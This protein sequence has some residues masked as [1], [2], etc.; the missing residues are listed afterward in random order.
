MD[1]RRGAKV[2][3][4]DGRA[5]GAEG[6][7]GMATTAAIAMVQPSRVNVFLLLCIALLLSWSRSCPRPDARKTQ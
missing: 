5:R 6:R 2:L 3:V 4:H 7:H 1:V